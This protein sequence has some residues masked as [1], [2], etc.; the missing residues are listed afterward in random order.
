MTIS[1]GLI[2]TKDRI[3]DGRSGFMAIW[4]GLGDIWLLVGV[5]SM[6]PPRL[7]QPVEE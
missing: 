6:G 2:R 7:G 3:V 5:F 4:V 1:H